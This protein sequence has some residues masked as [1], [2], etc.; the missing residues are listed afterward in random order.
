MQV[1]RRAALLIGVV[2]IL[3]GLGSA[4]VGYLLNQWGLFWI[5]GALALVG[6]LSIVRQVRRSKENRPA[7]QSEINA[8]V[9]Y[10]RQIWGYI[11]D[12]TE[13]FMLK[14]ETWQVSQNRVF[15]YVASR[16]YMQIT[17]FDDDSYQ[18]SL[19]KKTSHPAPDQTVR[20]WHL[21][22][23]RDLTSRVND[24]LD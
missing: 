5:S 2:A 7:S 15:I 17:L 13:R 19:F 6:I 22:R 11:P 18:I 20:L 8:L 4:A 23:A 16:L 9:A 24:T 1:T 10:V 14:D 3:L 21:L 12:K